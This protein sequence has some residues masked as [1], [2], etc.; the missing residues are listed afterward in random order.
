VISLRGGS[1][2]ANIQVKGGERAGHASN[3]TTK[4]KKNASND[5]DPH[6]VVVVSVV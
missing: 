1:T 2:A 3:K 6:V 5:R 4:K